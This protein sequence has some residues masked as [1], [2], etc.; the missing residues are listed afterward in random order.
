[1]VEEILTDEEWALRFW[2]RAEFG[3][4]TKI[5]FKEPTGTPSFPLVVIWGRIGG[6]P[7]A[8]FPIDQP[9]VSFH[10]WGGPGGGGR[11]LAVQARNKLVTLLNGVAD[12]L[13]DPTTVAMWA[14]VDSVQWTPD[15]SDESNPLARFT[16]DATLGIRSA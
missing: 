14:T 12:T 6:A 2:L 8:G 4:A 11:G 13:L 1:M 7:M 3:P 5:Y 15:E 9:R 16:V 10:C